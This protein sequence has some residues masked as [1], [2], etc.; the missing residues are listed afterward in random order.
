[1]QDIGESFFFDS[2]SSYFLYSGPQ[3]LGE[4]E[5]IGSFWSR[6]IFWFRINWI[7]FYGFTISLVAKEIK[8]IS[9]YTNYF[10]TKM[11]LKKLLFNIS[12][13]NWK[14]YLPSKNA[15]YRWHTMISSRWIILKVVTDTW[16]VKSPGSGQFCWCQR[17]PGGLTF[18]RFP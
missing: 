6:I 18:R 14:N 7:K 10:L 15:V 2:S 16:K 12:N 5:G 4:I 17:A 3:L 13:R 11:E 9:I 1:M 8:E